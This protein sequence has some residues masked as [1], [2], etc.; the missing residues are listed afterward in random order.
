MKKTLS[1]NG[2]DKVVGKN[3]TF[4]FDV[5]ALVRAARSAVREAVRQ[6]KRAG[7]QLRLSSMEK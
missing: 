4:N 7:T 1:S 3:G 2:K 5:P 6:H